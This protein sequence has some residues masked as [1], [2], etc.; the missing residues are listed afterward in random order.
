LLKVIRSDFN[1]PGLLVIGAYRDNEVDASHP[2][3]GFMGAQEKAGQP[4]RMLQLNNLQQQDLETFLGDTLRSQKGIQE[5]GTVIYEKT[6]GNP[7]FSRRLLASLNEEGRICYDSEINSWK[8]DVE[9]INAEAIADNVADLLAKKIAQLPEA[10]QTILKLAACIGNRF[11]T[12][13]LT[14]ISGLAEKELLKTLSESLR[15]QYVFGSDDTYEFVHDQVQQG[16][17]ALIAEED[18]PRVHLEIG[19]LLLSKTAAEKVGEDIFNIVHHFNAG[20]AL[21]KSESERISVAELN[22][23]AGQK[24]RNA[25]AY[26]EGFGYIEQGL[27]L[28][29]PD[30]W[31]DDYDLTLA[32]HNEAAELAYLTGQYDKLEEI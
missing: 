12:A 2:L 8:W 4:P 7:F 20:A 5:L 6:Q 21:L 27:A 30:S 29:G 25:A 26:A 14:V 31:Q 19:C 13:T 16:G 17:Y 10:T 32:L 9:A 1:Q 11:D 28:L 22:L 15:G 3:T 24:A 18:R 23:N